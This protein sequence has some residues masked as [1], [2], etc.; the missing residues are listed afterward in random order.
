MSVFVLLD[1]KLKPSDMSKLFFMLSFKILLFLGESLYNCIV[2][3]LKL[4]FFVFCL[5]NLKI[6]KFNFLQQKGILFLKFT[7]FF[8]ALFEFDCQIL[9]LSCMKAGPLESINWALLH[10]H[11]LTHS[12]VSCLIQNSSQ[13]LSF[14]KVDGR[15]DV[16][17]L[18]KA[19]LRALQSNYSLFN[20]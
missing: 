19:A 10:K 9:N 6:T 16:T 5:F 11:A 3:H 1:C 7:M 20:E 12:R 17:Q 14:W 4:S 2:L 8:A 18:I 13:V 15:S